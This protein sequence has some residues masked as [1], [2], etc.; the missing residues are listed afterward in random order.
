MGWAS[1]WVSSGGN[2][3]NRDL[4]FLYTLEELKPFLEGDIPHHRRAERAHV[5]DRRRGL[6]LTR[7][8][9]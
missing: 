4:G 9:D 5:R 7:D 1:T 3:F 8:P 2:D 6:R